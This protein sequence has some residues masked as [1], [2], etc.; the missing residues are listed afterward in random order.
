MQAVPGHGKGVNRQVDGRGKC[1]QTQKMVFYR[2]ALNTR[3][4][5]L[6]EVKNL[7]KECECEMDFP[8]TYAGFFAPSDNLFFL[9]L[10]FPFYSP[11][12]NDGTNELRFRE[13]VNNF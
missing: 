13:A 5:F 11:L 4:S 8:I 10:S 3:L 9:L 2:T 1:E 12:K 7:G 6:N